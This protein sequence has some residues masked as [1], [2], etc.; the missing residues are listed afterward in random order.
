MKALNV[1]LFFFLLTSCV[2][3]LRAQ[4][5][6][7]ISVEVKGLEKGDLMLGYHYGNNKYLIDTAKVVSPGRY[8]FQGFEKLDPGV[9]ILVLPGN[10]FFDIII[11]RTQIFEIV[12]STTDFLEN[13]SF[14]DSPENSSF[15]QYLRDISGFRQSISSNNVEISDDTTLEER[16]SE[17]I[18]ANRKLNLKI[19]ASQDSYIESFPNSL[20]SKILLAQREPE[21]TPAPEGYDEEE[22]RRF[23]YQQY[24]NRFWENFDFSDNRLLRSPAYHARLTQF[25]GEVLV[26]DPDTLT[27]E[28]DLMV[29]R[30]RENQDVFRYTVWFITN[31]FERSQI[32]GH[33]AV[34]VHMLEKY[35]LTDEAFWVTEESRTSLAERVRKMK[36]LLIGRVAPDI[37]VFFANRQRISLHS[38]E[39]NYTILYFWDSNCGHCKRETPRIE[40]I[41]NRFKDKGVKVFAMNLDGDSQSWQNAIEEYQIRHWINVTDPHNESGFREKFDVYATPII[42]LLD[43]EKRILAKRIDAQVL[44]LFMEKEIDN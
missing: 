34:F 33:D 15:F 1:V 12:T 10:T 29:N 41:Y 38:V 42:Y 39:A 28:A 44:E 3:S 6:Y 37:N 8:L 25:F 36:P 23:N 13:T 21:L 19:R 27:L 26:Q 43:H 7:L 22:T 18:E 31:H 11:D 16:R 9:Y 40:G 17:L 14:T 30:A 20:F 32:M 24:K 5:G 2:F 35:Y 4:D